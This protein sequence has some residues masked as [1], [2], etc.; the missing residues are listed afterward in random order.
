MN[1]TVYAYFRPEHELIR[2]KENKKKKL[3][4]GRWAGRAEEMW[5]TMCKQNAPRK[6]LEAVSPLPLRH[7]NQ[8]HALSK[9]F[10]I[11]KSLEGNF[12]WCSNPNRSNALQ[13]KKLDFP[14]SRFGLVNLFLRTV[15][16]LY[17]KRLQQQNKCNSEW[18]EQK[19]R[20][21]QRRVGKKE[22]KPRLNSNQKLC[23]NHNV[24]QSQIKSITGQ[25]WRHI[26]I[27]GC[28]NFTWCL[29][30][31]VVPRSLRVS[32]RDLF[33]MQNFQTESSGIDLL[34]P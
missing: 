5:W 23:Y 15:V 26:I 30:T 3:A 19:D 21:G 2:E 33:T 16:V 6:V 18:R 4:W 7:Y 17:W 31:N 34:H 9:F 25:F 22:R 32:P 10:E 27:L 8:G 11:F 14:R 24:R 12:R 1:M 13:R 20:G 28:I 29:H